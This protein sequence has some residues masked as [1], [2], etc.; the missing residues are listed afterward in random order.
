MGLR[1]Y[2]FIFSVTQ[3][4]ITVGGGNKYVCHVQCKE[5]VDLGG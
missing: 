1:L 3:N 2:P 4:V 5:L